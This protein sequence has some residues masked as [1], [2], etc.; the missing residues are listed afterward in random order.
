MHYAQDSL[1]ARAH[2]KAIEFKLAELDDIFA[3]FCTEQGY[4]FSRSLNIFPKCRVSRRQEIDRCIDLE[5]NVGFQ[6]VLDRGFYPE[7]PWSLYAR[8]SLHPGSDPDVHILSRPVFQNVPYTQLA[9]VLKGALARGLQ[10]V[11]AMTEKEVLAD[12]QT[13]QEIRDEAKSEY[14]AYRRAQESARGAEPGGST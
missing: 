14:E 2:L 8:A 1:E 11:N 12:G 6:D 10:I 5:F 4:R 9:S 7:L 3:H 13:A